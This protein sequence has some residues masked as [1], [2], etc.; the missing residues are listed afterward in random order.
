MVEIHPA[1]FC[2]L[3]FLSDLKSVVCFTFCPGLLFDVNM[4]RLK[5]HRNLLHLNIYDAFQ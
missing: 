2:I 5:Y 1:M 3:L 4:T